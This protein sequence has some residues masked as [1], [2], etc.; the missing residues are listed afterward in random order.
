[1]NCH[2]QVL[3]GLR[4]VFMSAVLFALSAP[5]A[6]A[7]NSLPAKELVRNDNPDPTNTGWGQ[8]VS[9]LG[10]RAIVAGSNI[11]VLGGA[12]IFEQ[13]GGQW[14]QKQR[15]DTPKPDPERG[16]G[17]GDLVE[18]DD[19]S[20]LLTDSEYGAAYYFQKS[21]SGNFRPTAILSGGAGFAKSIAMSGCFI[22]IG[23]P[24]APIQQAATGQGALHMYDKCGG[25]PEWIGSLYAPYAFA[26][27]QFSKSVALLGYEMLVGAP[28]MDGDAGAV[29]YY[30]YNG[31]KWVLKQKIVQAHP[32]P[33]NHFGSAVSFRNGLAVIGAPDQPDVGQ[34]EIFKRGSNGVWTSLGLLT[35]PSTDGTWKGFG[36]KL[37][38]TPDYV[39]VAAIAQFPD[40]LGAKTFVYR[41]AG[42]VLSPLTTLSF[43]TAAQAPAN[44]SLSV[45]G[46]GL[47][48][49]D[50]VALPPPPGFTQTSGTATIF[51]LPR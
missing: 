8:S 43:P 15:L 44:I 32:A 22:A 31:T 28:G 51:Q 16:K 7:Q 26:G 40:M 4:A 41:R 34:A 3:P 17:M 37:V 25:N 50:P 18:Q 1:M 12:Y 38:V 47:I 11:T 36:R 48:V 29:F 21:A 33:G 23:S 24:G 35:L 42:D 14:I 5:I 19:T 45:A 6:Y 46:Q 13:S 2:C 39:V 20:V 9:L 49:G 10:G 30:T 27:D